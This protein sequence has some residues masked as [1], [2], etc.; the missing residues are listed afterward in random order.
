MKQNISTGNII[1]CPTCGREYKS[2]ASMKLHKK[3]YCQKQPSMACSLC[4]YKAYHRGNLKRHVTVHHGEEYD[5]L[6][7]KIV[8]SHFPKNVPCQA[9]GLVTVAWKSRFTCDTCFK[10]YDKETSLYYHR[11][12]F[13]C[14]KCNKLFTLKHNLN[15]HLRAYCGVLPQFSCNMQWCDY[16]CKKKA[17]LQRHYLTHLRAYCGKPPLFC[18]VLEGC[19]YKCKKKANLQRHYIRKH[20]DYSLVYA[21]HFPFECT[22]CK[23]RYKYK[24]NLMR[25]LKFECKQKAQFICQ[26]EFCNYSSNFK[27]NLERHIKLRHPEKISNRYLVLGSP[28]FSCEACHKGYRHRQS[29]YKHKRFECGKPP[30]FRC[31]YNGC[32]FQTNVKGNLTQHLKRHL[33]RESGYYVSIQPLLD[34]L[35]LQPVNKRRISTSPTKASPVPS[36]KQKSSFETKTTTVASTISQ[37]LPTFKTTRGRKKKVWK[38]ETFYERSDGKKIQVIRCT[39][40]RT[41]VSKDATQCKVCVNKALGIH[42]IRRKPKEPKTDENK[43]DTK[44]Q[45]ASKKIKKEI[46]TPPKSVLTIKKED[47]KKE[48][49]EVEQT[50]AS[51]L[52]GTDTT[53][54]DKKRKEKPATVKSKKFKVLGGLVKPV[55]SR[56]TLGCK[57]CPSCRTFLKKPLKGLCEKCK[58]KFGKKIA[59]KEEEIINIE[60]QVGDVAEPSG[61]TGDK[62]CVKI[63]GDVVVSKQGNV[64]KGK[65]PTPKKGKNKSSEGVGNA[66]GLLKDN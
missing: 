49:I 47:V 58:T 5:P 6:H 46:G 55:K 64:A 50:T 39:T 2:V 57:R 48:T 16:K 65:Q 45:K 41:F 43:A 33:K 37:K 56:C 26:Y 30:Q 66:S 17:N 4:D 10:V 27:A 62:P 32:P 61:K 20:N 44:N 18:C 34:V 63:L 31:F 36:K 54:K 38:M 23:R 21:E 22:R 19:D 24:G 8:A 52:P 7:A 28:I 11:L 40:C 1:P 9:T 3:Y 53:K 42:V 13:V 35:K 60:E 15:T 25:H 59:K 14:P 29:L 12:S 51:K